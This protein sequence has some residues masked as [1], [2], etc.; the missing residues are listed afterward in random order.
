MCGYFC[1]EFND[2][3][4]KGKSFL[5]YVNLISPNGYE[6]YNKIILKYIHN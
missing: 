4:L 2:F 1:I 3:I 5:D 6:K